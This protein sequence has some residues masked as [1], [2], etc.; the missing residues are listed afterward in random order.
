MT[1]TD[2]YPRRAQPAGPALFAP[3]TLDENEILG[4]HLSSGWYKQSAVYPT[5]SE[6]WHETRALLQDPQRAW[7][8]AWDE[9]HPPEGSPATELPEPEAV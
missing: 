5:Q 9:S 2:P 8:I 3:L 1:S 6:Q 4:A 7:D